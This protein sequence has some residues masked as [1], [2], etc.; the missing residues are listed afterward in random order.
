MRWKY[1]I[2]RNLIRVGQRQSARCLKIPNWFLKMR[3]N[4]RYVTHLKMMHR[5]T[6]H[7]IATH[8]KAVSPSTAGIQYDPALIGTFR[9]HTSMLAVSQ[10]DFVLTVTHQLLSD[11]G[12]RVLTVGTLEYETGGDLF[13]T[14]LLFQ[15]KNPVCQHCF[16]CLIKIFVL[17]RDICNR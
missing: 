8:R 12:L 3:N 5:P 17:L 9:F 7:S 16:R 14:R 1:G 2:L 10:R 4:L 15:K 6:Y 11:W 13:Q